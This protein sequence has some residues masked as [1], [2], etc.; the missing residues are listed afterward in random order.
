MAAG[1]KLF[2]GCLPYAQNEASLTLL[3]SQFG[4]VTEAAILRN[5]ADGSSKGAAFVTFQEAE[6]ATN[7]LTYLQGHVFE[8]STRGINLSYATSTA[9]P[10]GGPSYVNGKGKG[11]VERVGVVVPPPPAGSSHW[12]TAAGLK[13]QPPPPGAQPPPPPHS[14][15]L[16]PPPQTQPVPPPPHSPPPPGVAQAHGVNYGEAYAETYAPG[17]RGAHSDDPPGSK[18]FLGQ[19]PFSR[20]ED[21]LWQLFSVLGQVTEVKLLRDRNTGAPRGAA[22]VRY[23]SA[24]LAASAIGA[25]D[26]FTFAGETRPMSVRL[27]GAQ[28][29]APA[30]A[31]PA[32]APAAY[33]TAYAGPHAE[34]YTPMPGAEAFRSVPG[35]SLFVGQL[36][37]SRSERDIEDIFSSYGP[38]A[39][40][41]IHRN[42]QTGQKNGGA[43]VTYTDPA[44]AAAALMLDGYTFEGATRP[45]TVALKGTEGPKRR[46]MT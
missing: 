19:L 7:A 23:A 9:G 42:P 29:G 8:G 14:Q 12:Q 28:G 22:F 17:G 11:G 36:P 39:E 46:R 16:P 15:P 10:G 27:A 24:E 30:P 4:V 13:Q 25:L 34:P 3:F 40:V 43:F 20:S 44:H 33:A 41:F 18:L 5:P 37:F 1:N 45:V 31:P 2:V 6:C 26:G 21:D 38:V 35:C 32:T